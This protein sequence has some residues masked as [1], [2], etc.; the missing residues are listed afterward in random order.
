MIES[1]GHAIHVDRPEVVEA[2][3]VE[4]LD[5]VRAEQPG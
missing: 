4:V 2:A 1:T 3:I 5:L